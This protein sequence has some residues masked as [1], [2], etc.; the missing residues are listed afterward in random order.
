MSHRVLNVGCRRL[1]PLTL[2]VA[3]MA[4]SGCSGSG[5]SV[6]TGTVQG[7]VLFKGQP[8]TKGTVY[9][10]TAKG[11]D[12]ASGAIQPDGTYTASNQSGFSIPAGDYA[13]S[14]S[15]IAAESGAPL[16]P[17]TLMEKIEKEGLPKPSEA[18]PE[19]YS[20]PKKSG[21]IA[22][23]KEGSNTADFDLK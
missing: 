13:V 5:S 7:K 8:L 16:D 14:V 15:V 19:K 21:L 17:T 10:F 11:G 20:D 23:V 1:L 6:K 18:I 9:F 2:L 3:T 4:L 12:S 22:V